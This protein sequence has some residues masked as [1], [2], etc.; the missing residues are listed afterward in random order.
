[1]AAF[2]EYMREKE[3]IDELLAS[4]Y[5]ITAIREDLDG[6]AV[7]FK[8]AGTPA[9]VSELQLLTADARKYVVTLLFAA[10]QETAS[11]SEPA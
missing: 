7:L 2:D 4:G 5:R 11:A 3:S 6:A 9:E 8:R 1:M 10:L